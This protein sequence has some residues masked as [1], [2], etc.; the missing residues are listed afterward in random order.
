MFSVG[1]VGRLEL[2]AAGHAAA[3]MGEQ[4]SA[5]DS[6]RETSQGRPAKATAAKA[7]SSNKASPKVQSLTMKKDNLIL[8]IWGGK[9]GE[10]WWCPKAARVQ[11]NTRTIH[12][13]GRFVGHFDVLQTKIVHCVRDAL[14]WLGH[15]KY[16]PHSPSMENSI[17]FYYAIIT[18]KRA[19]VSEAIAW[20]AENK[21]T[22]RQFFYVW[23]DMHVRHYIVHDDATLPWQFPQ[24][25]AKTQKGTSSRGKQPDAETPSY[26]GYDIAPQKTNMLAR[27]KMALSS[28]LPG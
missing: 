26:R 11:P 16:V 14:E 24:E 7:I 2:T 5:S 20:D 9:R 23:E 17:T 12:S 10:L 25:K 4:E 6:L 27:T 1:P 21:R 18:N 15:G 22:G 8:K 3:R 13:A 28:F 19:D